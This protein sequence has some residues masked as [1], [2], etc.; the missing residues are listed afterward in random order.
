VR[1]LPVAVLLLLAA[2]PLQAQWQLAARHGTAS[3]HGDAE[4]D[5]DPAHAALQAYRPATWTVAL[6]RDLGAW[7]LALELHRT[8]ADL[9]EVGPS[10]RVTTNDVLAAWGTALEFGLR[11]AGQPGRAML[12]LGGGG[13]IDR[14]TFDVAVNSPRTRVAARG[15]LDAELPIGRQWGAVIRT[16]LLS[17]P[18]VFRADELPEGFSTRRATRIGVALGLARRW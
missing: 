13:V 8:T 16:E 9:A 5:L 17:G 4:A 18:S 14:W 2:P 7:R 1:R 11:L 6:A 12:W 15:S 3:S 10:S